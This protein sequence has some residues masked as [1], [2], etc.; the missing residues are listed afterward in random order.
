[1]LDRKNNITNGSSFLN[2][3]GYSKMFREPGTQNEINMNSFYL[4]QHECLL[5]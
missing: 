3:N 4:D 1:M 5:Q 2:R